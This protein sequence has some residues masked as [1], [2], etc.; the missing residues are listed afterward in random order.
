MHLICKL[1]SLAGFCLLLTTCTT[2][3]YKESADRESYAAIA[4]KADQVP[5]MSNELDIDEEK[6]VDVSAFLVNQ[7]S[8]EFLDNES[9]S[10]IGASVIDLESALDLAF[11]HSREYQTQKELLY[12]EA[13]ALTFDRYR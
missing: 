2:G 3:Q 12:L 5:G 11:Q 8:F 9:E 13:L 7:D 4:G 10:E 6:I 1:M